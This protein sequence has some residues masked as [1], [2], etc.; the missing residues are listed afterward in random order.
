MKIAFIADIHGNAIALENVLNDMKKRSVD[1]IYVLGDLCYRG[2]EPKR[3]LELIRDLH[4][5]VIKGN[6]DEWVVRGVQQG[7]VPD[8]ALD[9]MNQE[10]NWTCSQLEKD[11]FTYLNQLPIEIKGQFE[12]VSF[13]LFHATPTSLFDIVLP[14]AE[15]HMIESKLMS[16]SDSDVYVYAH[17]HRPYIRFIDGKM[18]IN[19]GSVGLPFDGLARA[20]YATIEVENGYVNPSIHRVSYDVDRVARQ[21]LDFEY[22]HAEMMINV[23]IN[24]K[25]G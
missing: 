25:I 3:S 8:K 23:L 24:A 11:D 19:T 5:E 16:Y 20:S 4:T 12:D 15:D 9:Q 1:K 7:E 18:I 6:A 17:I 13:H 2:P 14:S 22:P 21:Y 10:K